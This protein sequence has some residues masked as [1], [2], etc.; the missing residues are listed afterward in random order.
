MVKSPVEQVTDFES[1]VESI[2]RPDPQVL[3]SHGA[4]LMFSLA[5]VRKTPAPPK[6]ANMGELWLNDI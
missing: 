6:L 5:H 3:D 2:L 1:L 4:S